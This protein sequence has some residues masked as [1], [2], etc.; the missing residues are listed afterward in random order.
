MIH[1]TI[2]SQIKSASVT[3]QWQTDIGEEETLDSVRFGLNPPG[4]LTN[5]TDP[6]IASNSLNKEVTVGIIPETSYVLAPASLLGRNELD[7]AINVYA[8]GNPAY[9]T[10]VTSTAVATGSFTINWE[11]LD[12]STTSTI[13]GL[14][15]GIGSLDQSGIS[16]FPSSSTSK[17]FSLTGLLPGTEYM[18]LPISKIG[19]YE[20]GCSGTGCQIQVTTLALPLPPELTPLS[21]PIGSVAP[22]NDGTIGSQAIG[23]GTY[24]GNTGYV[25]ADKF[26]DDIKR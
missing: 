26:I 24:Q 12:D 11:T 20:F 14:Y 22:Q 21:D 9:I 19:A 17:T 4:N 23:I 16:I 2:I 18:V 15:Y 7:G 8:T 6:P 1:D 3:I 13:D 5:Q 10:N 25:S